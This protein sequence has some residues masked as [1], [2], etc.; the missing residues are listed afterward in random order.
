MKKSN[1]KNYWLLAQQV[2]K[3]NTESLRDLPKIS[4]KVL[5]R[6]PK[7]H[8]IPQKIF[9]VNTIF[10]FSITSLFF[11]F[12]FDLYSSFPWHAQST[13]SFLPCPLGM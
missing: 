12:L 1:Y 7:Y 11:Y 5:Y 13:C 4:Q 8:F 2:E 10:Q 9:F 6:E 3:L